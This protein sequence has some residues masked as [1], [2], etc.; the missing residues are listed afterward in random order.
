MKIK[1]LGRAIAAFVLSVVLAA[2]PFAGMPAAYAEEAESS[3]EKIED[4]EEAESSNE[5]IEDPEEGDNSGLPGNTD[6]QEENGNHPDAGGDSGNPEETGDESDEGTGDASDEEAGTDDAADSVNGSEAEAEDGEAEEQNEDPEEQ[7]AN[8]E[9]ASVEDAGVLESFSDMPA[10]Y[11]LTSYQQE[12]KADLTADLDQIRESD[13]GV[14]YAAGRVFT[15]A[16]SREEAELIAESYHA[17]IEDFSMG[18]LTLRL[19]EDTTVRAAVTAAASMDNSLPAV[20]PDYRRE[21]YEEAIPETTQQQ[22]GTAGLEVTE[23]EYSIEEYSADGGPALSQAEEESS[24]GV[25]YGQ[26]LDELSGFSDPYLNPASDRYQWFHTAVGSLYAWKAGYTGQSVTVGVIDTGVSSNPDLDDNLTGGY[27]FCDGTTETDDDY[28]HGTHVAGTIAALANGDQGVGVAPGAKIYNAKVFGNDPDKS[29]YDSTIMKAI[30]YLINEEDNSTQRVNSAKPRVDIIN[31]SLGGSGDTKGFQSVLDKA[32][33]KGVI[34]FAATGNDGAS[35]MMYPASY[36]HVV[37]VAATDINNERAYFSNYGYKTDLAAP[38]VDIWAA[39]TDGKGSAV[40]ESLQG[41]SMACPVAAGEA[42]VILSGLADLPDLR[43]KTGAARVDALEAIMKENAVGAGDGMGGGIASLAKVFQLDTA[44]MKPSAPDIDISDNSDQKGQSVEVTI[45]AQPGTRLCYT[46]DGKDPVYKYEAAGANTTLVDGHVISFTID[47]SQAAK[48][49]VKAFAISRDGVISAVKSKNYKLSP[50]V[51]E[52]IVSGPA[53]VERGRS[54]RLT[55]VVTP[56]CAANKKVTWD[57]RDSAGDPVETAR[58]RIDGNGKITVADTADLG[59]YTVIIQTGDGGGAETRYPIQVIEKGTAVVSLAFD[60]KITKELWLTKE[61]PAPTMDLAEVLTVTEKDASGK[62]LEYRGD[63]LGDRVV[64]TSS[65]P[66]A[67]EVDPRGVVTAKSTGTVTITARAND[68]SNKMASV[69][70]SIKQGVTGITITTAKGKTDEELFTVAAGRSMT[71]K[72]SVSP[73]RPADKKVQW[74]ISPVSPNVTINRTSGRISVKPGTESGS[75]I[76]TATASDK[77]GAAAH[78]EVKVFGG[79]VGKIS[80]DEVKATLYTKKVDDVK[81]DTKVITATLTGVNGR[82]DFDPNA[83]TVT[84]SNEAIVKVT[85]RPAQEEN[86]VKVQITLTSAGEKY[87]KAKVTVASTDGSNKKAVCNV[88]VSGRI[89]SVAMQDTAGKKAGSLNLFRAVGSGAPESAVLRAVIKGSEGFNPASCDVS[90]SNPAL[91]KVSLDKQTN[92]IQISASDRS[93]GKA[94]VTLKATDG[95][96]RKASCS[97]TV[98][99][100]VSRIN[101]APKAGTTRYVV[102]GR[103]VQLTAT[104]ETEYGK[105]S[106]PK[107]AWEL[108]NTATGMNITVNS[109]GKVTVPAGLEGKTEDFTVTAAA[110]DGSGVKASYTIRLRPPTTKFEIRS[111]MK[112]VY[113]VYKLYTIEF[114]S[115]CTSPVSCTSSDPETAAPSIAYIP[116]NPGTKRGGTG[117]ISFMATRAGDVTFK[118]KALDTSDKTREINCR[119]Q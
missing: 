43:E 22:D 99:N 77:K 74:S 118:I 7:A 29:G 60:K 70:I 35:T 56:S 91:V 16:R 12:L 19:S 32:R 5:R 86:G 20:W 6:V 37:A 102:S 26:A 10:A 83:Y 57:L 114:T 111:K 50:Y 104:F 25:A 27:N 33:D 112:E 107:V 66:T 48:G 4:P 24:A 69:K 105:A 42:A 117:S 39:S 100:P 52:I 45:T 41:T 103:S 23:E 85:A 116:Y 51:K 72:A 109:A 113:D 61:I 90:S 67:A 64:W 17:K 9:N 59:V 87:G 49:T 40:Y 63:D 79:A 2:E 98:S 11:R 8:A 53:K 94:T 89:T 55:A 71:L 101:I 96:G 36:E 62:K 15:F 3:K 44:V 82:T 97:V 119:F 58:I 106:D 38:G 75:Y 31:M 115:D 78:Q 88:T 95:S 65:R 30:L 54:I 84:S 34:V 14:A 108:S 73:A 13:E 18:V 21:L 46:T 110:K 1:K 93:T 68:N 28:R 47:G 80:L 81:T 76:V 92:M